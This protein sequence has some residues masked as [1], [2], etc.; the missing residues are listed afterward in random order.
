MKESPKLPIEEDPS[1]LMQSENPGILRE[2]FQF[3]REH[4]KLWLIPIFL[5]LLLFSLVILVG[6]SSAAPFI[7]RL[8]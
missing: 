2:F 5:I 8:F 7:Y 3:A 6:G 4:K 1:R